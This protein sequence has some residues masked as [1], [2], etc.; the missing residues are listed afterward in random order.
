MKDLPELTQDY[1]RSFV[2]PSHGDL[3]KVQA[4]LADDPRLLDV[5]YE[6]WQETPLGAASHV[7]NRPIAEFLLAQGAKMTIYA[8]AMLGRQV[9]VAT[10]LE[11]EPQLIN[12]GGAHNISLLFHAA[13]SGDLSLLD[14]LVDKG[15]TQKGDDVLPIAARRGDLALAQWLLDHGAGVTARNFQDK[16]ALQIAEEG[17]E[18]AV[19]ALLRDYGATE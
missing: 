18:E 1:I 16:T 9:N 3:A 12:S 5:M 6:D 19:A 10:F 8:A 15:N 13:L 2:M 17:K 4:M 7:G 11:A 14:F